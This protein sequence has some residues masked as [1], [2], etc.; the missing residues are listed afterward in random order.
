M[1]SMILINRNTF[2]NFE[3]ASEFSTQYSKDEYCV[4]PETYDKEFIV[5]LNIT[6]NNDNLTIFSNATVVLK[7]AQ[8]IASILD[9]RKRVRKLQLEEQWSNYRKQKYPPL[10]DYHDAV[11]WRDVKN[12]GS[13]LQAYFYTCDNVKNSVPKLQ[14]ISNGNLDVSHDSFLKMLFDEWV[15]IKDF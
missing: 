4:I 7:T 5:G 14:D 10:E 1:D 9:V 3:V 2:E 12:D 15:L 11:Y 8:Q 6:K 13:H